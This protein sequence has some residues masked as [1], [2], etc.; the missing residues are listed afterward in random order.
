[1]R[2]TKELAE[3]IEPW[4][5]LVAAV[6]A[7]LWALGEY[8]S[9]V[10]EGRVEK[11]LA[12]VERFHEDPVGPAWQQIQ[13]AWDAREKN[14]LALLA[15]PQSEQWK[16]R[17]GKHVRDLVAEARLGSPIAIVV[18]FFHELQVCAE[19]GICDAAAARAFF[20]VQATEFYHQHYCYL[21]ARRTE[22]K[23]PAFGAAIE[24]MA[25]TASSDSCGEVPDAPPPPS[26]GIGGAVPSR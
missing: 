25:E 23:D 16:A 5:R 2:W 8:R 20:K 18:Q 22:L 14:T 4:F 13:D 19:A 26:I 9:R 6:V 12:Y 7:A 10:A 24:W 3:K 17:W 1:M 11:T 21:L 15:E